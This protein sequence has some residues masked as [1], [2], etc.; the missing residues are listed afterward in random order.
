MRNLISG[1]TLTEVQQVLGPKEGLESFTSRCTGRTLARALLF[2]STVMTQGSLDLKPL[3]GNFGDQEIDLV[4]FQINQRL[5]Q[6]GLVGFSWSG[7]VLNYYPFEEYQDVK[8]IVREVKVE[9]SPFNGEMVAPRSYGVEQ[10]SEGP[11]IHVESVEQS[12]PEVR[13]SSSKST[14]IGEMEVLEP[15]VPDMTPPA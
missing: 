15:L 5:D 7:D 13:V 14:V 12:Y 9:V 3:R 1:K 8:E 2:I 4:K 6:M 10:H 11:A